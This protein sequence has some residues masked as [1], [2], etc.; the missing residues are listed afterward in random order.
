MILG[1]YYLVLKFHIEINLS[2]YLGELLLPYI[3][4]CIR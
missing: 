2:L 3:N 4:S 1:I